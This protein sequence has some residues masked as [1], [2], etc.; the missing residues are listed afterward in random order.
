MSFLQASFKNIR[1]AIY[2]VLC[3]RP[4]RRQSCNTQGF[5][6]CSLH[7][8]FSRLSETR[9]FVEKKREHFPWG[10]R[11]NY[12]STCIPIER[13]GLNTLHPFLSSREKYKHKVFTELSFQQSKC[14]EDCPLFCVEFQ[15][16][17][18]FEK[19]PMVDGNTT[20]GI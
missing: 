3:I 18:P 9:D 7:V 5:L 10:T 12:T 17:S 11:F 19:N 15:S 16:F 1:N 13:N 14:R 20:Q 2:N 8:S 4:N 6:P